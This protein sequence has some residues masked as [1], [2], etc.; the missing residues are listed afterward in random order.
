ML[1]VG[2]WELEVGSWELE[3]GSLKFG[4]LA[5]SKILGS[6]ELEFSDVG[7]EK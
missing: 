4:S 7:A 3:V 6:W 5:R 1:E 2:R